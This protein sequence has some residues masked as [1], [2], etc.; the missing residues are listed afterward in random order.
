MFPDIRFFCT[1]GAVDLVGCFQGFLLLH[2]VCGGFN[3]SKLDW[4]S[5]PVWPFASLRNTEALWH[6]AVLLLQFIYDEKIVWWVRRLSSRPLMPIETQR[7]VSVLSGGRVWFW[8]SC[9]QDTSSSWSESVQ[10]CIWTEESDIPHF[11]VVEVVIFVPDR[12]SGVLPRVYTCSLLRI[13]CQH[14]TTQ[15]QIIKTLVIVQ[16]GFFLI[17]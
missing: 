11:S 3:C 5:P 2:H 4:I 16:S 17:G 9:T 13:I 12:S 8:S 1:G 7:Y 10:N 6:L 14:G 15:T